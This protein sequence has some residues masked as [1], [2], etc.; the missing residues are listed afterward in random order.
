MTR[1]LVLM[2][3]CLCVSGLLACKGDKGDKGDTGQTGQQGPAGPKGDTGTF[4]SSPGAILIETLDRAGAFTDVARGVPTTVSGGTKVGFGPTSE[5]AAGN[6]WETT[7]IG[8][9]V[10]VDLGA[11]QTGVFAVLFESN[12]RGDPTHIPAFSGTSAY[13]L[14]YSSDNF[15]SDIHDVPAVTPAQGDLFI[16]RFATPVSFRYLRI[17]NNGPATIPNAVRISMLRILANDPGDATRIDAS[18]LYNSC[19]TGFIAASGGHLCVESGALHAAA[20]FYPALATCKGIAPGCRVC[21]YMD[22][23]QACA[24]GFNPFAGVQPGWYGDHETLTSGNGDDSY[25]T[26]NATACTDNA[27]G[28]ATNSASATY[29]FRC[30]Y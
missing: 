16:H 8:S 18:R 1:W 9:H 27:D 22:F 2:V 4:N 17:S 24:A 25:L 20:Q 12:P 5:L 14:Q 10:D 11:A 7:Q 3:S 19:R 6:Y 15:A 23:Q 29:P 21:T 30:C 13:A 28:P 26:W